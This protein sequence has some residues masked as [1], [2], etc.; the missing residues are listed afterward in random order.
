[1]R[2]HFALAFTLIGVLLIASYADWVAPDPY[3]LAHSYSIGRAPVWSHQFSSWHG[4]H[5]DRGE[6]GLLLVVLFTLA[7]VV[8]FRRH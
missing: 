7:G 6:T 2:K 4:A 5:V 3:D 1:M 8:A